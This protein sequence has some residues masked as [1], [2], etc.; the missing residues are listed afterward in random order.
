MSLSISGEQFDVSKMILDFGGANFDLPDPNIEYFCSKITKAKNFTI[1]MKLVMISKQHPEL[2][3]TYIDTNF[4]IKT[5]VGAN[6]TI[7]DE[8]NVKNS[9]GWTAL[10]LACRNSN[11]YTSESTVRLL[12][13]IGA[14]PNIQINLGWTPLQ[15]ASRHSRTD[16]TESTVQLLLRNG[17]NPN[18]VDDRVSSPL[19]LACNNVNGDSTE[20]TVELLL[21]AGADINYNNMNM[22]IATILIQKLT[23]QNKSIK[24]ALTV[25]SLL[26]DGL[27]AHETTIMS[28][29]CE[30][31]TSHTIASDQ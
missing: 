1:L 3:K 6:T 17:A 22:D 21:D 27:I 10:H 13:N 5:G 23:R 30:P 2:L 4:N 14:N 18:L 11:I 16:S 15:L 29:I 25:K 19:F 20:S 31:S 12:L 26:R 28:Y 7:S 24:E 9:A 8:V